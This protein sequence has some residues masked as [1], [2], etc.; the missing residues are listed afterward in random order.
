VL[1]DTL[2]KLLTPEMQ[3]AA[4]T[5]GAKLRAD[6][7]AAGAADEIERVFGARLSQLSAA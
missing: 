1:D 6:P 7:G 3:Q 5:L 4:Q 2:A